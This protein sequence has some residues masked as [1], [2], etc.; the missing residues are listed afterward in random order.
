[1]LKQRRVQRSTQVEGML[2]SGIQE[3]NFVSLVGKPA[4]RRAFS[5]IR[6]EGTPVSSTTSTRQTRT[7]RSDESKVAALT[8]PATFTDEQVNDTLTAY[9]LT[10]LTVT[11]SDNA[12]VAE[13]SD[14]QS[15]SKD[16][17]S[18][19]KL[20]EDGITATVVRSEGESTTQGKAQISV[21]SLEFSSDNFS[22]E[23]VTGWLEENS[24]DFDDKALDNSSGNFVVQRSV[25]AEG[26]EI[27]QIELSEGVIAHV[28][29]SDDLDVP[30]GFVTVI[31][32]TAYGHWGWGLLD[33]DARLADVEVGNKLRKGL[34]YLDDILRD[35]LFYSALPIDSRKELCKRS[36]EQFGAY[37]TGLLDSLPRQ[38]LVQVNTQRNDRTQEP[39]MSN[40]KP[41]D[42]ITVT[43]AELAQVVAEGVSLALAKRDEGT[44][45]AADTTAATTEQTPAATEQAP[46]AATEQTAAPAA[47]AATPAAEQT[48]QPA[49]GA[50]LTRADLTDVL[51]EV[52]A[53]VSQRLDR[54]ES[55]SVV[56]SDTSDP[57]QAT[58]E[59][60]TASTTVQ[61]SEDPFKGV[62]S[63]G[64]R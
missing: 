55:T 15:I 7:K 43:R 54:L 8:F 40:A 23:D 14:L 18:D 11:R 53:P 46:A 28:Q 62:L 27:R 64:G 6:Q 38:L 58:Q 17:L 45:A 20:T 59:Q 63:L 26:E 16:R 34:E 37:A 32:E 61:R 49:A 36:L 1:M 41:E 4:N 52:M 56:R 12:V 51:K 47:P 13:R 35:V 3:A 33:F 19:I 10:G 29:R 31:C 44:P 2:I 5:L 42:K 21:V 24:I 9:G 60:Q 22:R 25:A 57:K 30:L 48:Q 50:A 39:V